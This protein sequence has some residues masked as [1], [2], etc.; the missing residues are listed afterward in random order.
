M[1]YQRPKTLEQALE[2]LRAGQP[3]SG[4]TG[5]V[6]HR[7]R[8][9]SVIDVQDLGMDRIESAGDRLVVGAS[10]RLQALVESPAGVPLALRIACRHEAALNLR[11]MATL[12]GTIVGGDG[13]SPVLTAALALGPQVRLEP[14]GEVRTVWQILE[15]RGAGLRGWLITAFELPAVRWSGYLQVGRAPL[16][17]PLVCAAAARRADGS[18]GLALGGYG[19]RPLSLEGSDLEQ[20]ARQAYAEAGDA[21]AGADYRADVAGVLVRRLLAQEAA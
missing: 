9:H 15:G 5:T 11:N 16:D 18:L 1:D 13:R 6:P 4:G 2:G 3:L 10:A 21:W 20:A 17:R 14:G 19:D 8:L 12:A 7:L